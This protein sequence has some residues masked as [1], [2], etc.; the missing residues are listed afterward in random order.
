MSVEKWFRFEDR[1]YS[2]VDEFDNHC[3]SY[4]DVILMEFVVD[5]HTPKGVWLRTFMGSRRF[6]LSSARKRFACPTIEEAAESF[7][8]RKAAQLRIYTAK[9]SHVHSALLCLERAVQ[10]RRAS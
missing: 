10:A 6:V 2:T 4:V 5:R 7:R 3:G 8:A 1:R 9:V